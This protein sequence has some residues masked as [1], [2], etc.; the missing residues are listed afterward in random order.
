MNAS[1]YFHTVRYLRPIQVAG[2]IWFKVHKPAPDLSAAPPLRAPRG[3]WRSPACHPARQL[4]ARRFRFLNREGELRAPHDWND[5]TVPKLWLYNLHYFDDLNATQHEA[6]HEWHD[7]LIESWIDDN[8]PATGTGWEPYPLSL[9]VV[10][11]IKWGLA[12]STLTPRALHSLSVQARYLSQRLE[13]HLLGNHLLANAKALIFAGAFFTGAEAQTWLDKGLTIWSDQL[14][15]QVLPDG[16]H[17][18]RSPMYHAIILED[19]LDVINLLDTLEIGGER[20]VQDEARPCAGAMLAWLRAMTHPDGEIA[21]LNDSA[22]GIAASPDELERYARSLGVQPGGLARESGVVH[23]RATGYISVVGPSA[24]A[25]LDVGPI[26]PDYLPGHAHADTLSFELSIDGRRTIVDS[27]TSTYEKDAERERQRSSS[28]HNTVE[29]DGENSSDVWGGFRVGRRAYPLD[30]Q[31]TASE[32]S[33]E[34][35]CAHDGY[36]RLAG[37]PV[38]RREWRFGD[39]RLTITDRIDGRFRTAVAR[40]HVH[41]DCELTLSD[42]SR[43]TIRLTSARKIHWSVENGRARIANTSYHPEFG[44]SLQNSCLQVDF[45]NAEART[46]FDWRT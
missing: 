21:L 22:F 8:A 26:G 32:G 28:A 14:R 9:R 5:P 44:T 10:N 29:I 12:G 4:G 6:R 42:H 15:E 39:D 35:S 37:S 31:V 41:P 18:E 25:Y 1:R 40:F 7:K 43:G 20:R 30:L 13:W 38:H 19:V 36:E 11:W 16:G 34:V 2:R 24:A 17:F 3:R 33:V 45:S 27:G 23:L 46:I